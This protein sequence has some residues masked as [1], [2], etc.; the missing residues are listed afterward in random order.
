MK[1]ASTTPRR[2]N[3]VK[4]NGSRKNGQKRRTIVLFGLCKLA[5][6][7][8]FFAHIFLAASAAIVIFVP[9]MIEIAEYMDLI[10][11]GMMAALWVDKILQCFFAKSER[12]LATIATNNLNSDNSSTIDS[13]V[14]ISVTDEGGK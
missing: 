12:R 1:T 5:I 10:A 11:Y 2:T 9:K 7:I 4:S 6:F 8:L 14:V 13:N 3:K